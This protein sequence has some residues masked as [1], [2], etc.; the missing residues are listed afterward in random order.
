MNL[1]AHSQLWK[2]IQDFQLD[3]PGAAIKFSD[4]LA[5]QQKWTASY[6]K[7]VIEEYRRF[8]FLCCVAPKGASPSKA[9]DEAWHLHLT[10][11]QSYWIQ[12]CKETLGKDIHHFPSKGGTQ[13]N[14]KHDT[15]YKETLSF[16]RIAFGTAAPKDIWPSPVTTTI[17]TQHSTGTL[18]KQTLLAVLAV[19]LLPFL[20]IVWTYNQSNPFAI[21]GPHFVAFYALLV[22]AGLISFVLLQRATNRSA[23]DIISNSF[24]A[25]VNMFEAAQFLY[26][27]HRAIQ[28][29]ILDLMDRNLLEL[30]DDMTFVVHRDKYIAPQQEKNPLV[31]GLLKGSYAQMVT[32]DIIA[33]SWYDKSDFESPGLLALSGFANRNE[34]FLKKYFIIILVTLIG[35]ARMVQGLYNDRPIIFLFLEISGLLL[36]CWFIEKRVSIGAYVFKKVR[37]LYTDKL[38]AQK[39]SGG[40]IIPD[41]VLNGGAALSP[42]TN[43][44]LI[45]AVFA[46]YY[47]THEPFNSKYTDSSYYPSSCLSLIHI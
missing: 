37:G 21:S 34:P 23:N 36:L 24:P 31:A 45:A 20:Y 32:Y 8:L 42:L 6:T 28:A 43:T 47:I 9:V 2:R 5:A 40:G 7:R 13:E 1:P 16:Y 30:K 44:V 29:A 39:N 12:L 26:G 10:Y 17:L 11:T 18:E 41:F 3:E 33:G 35:L 19:M 15:W 14:H 25:D 46:P 27:K 4:K 38:D 22:A